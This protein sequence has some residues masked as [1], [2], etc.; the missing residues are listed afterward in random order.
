MDA[1]GYRD[2]DELMIHGYGTNIARDWSRDGERINTAP[3]PHTHIHN[4]Y[5][6]YTAAVDRIAQ[7]THLTAA[8]HTMVLSGLSHANRRHPAADTRCLRSASMHSQ[9]VPH[10]RGP[11]NLLAQ[12]LKD[13]ATIT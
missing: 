2:T 9:L 10:G 12:L 4:S 7:V 11:A 8:V 6:S 3:P 5:R 1:D 13:C